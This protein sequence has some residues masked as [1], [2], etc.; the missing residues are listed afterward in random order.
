[1]S[2]ANQTFPVAGLFAAAKPM[3]TTGP[4]AAATAFAG[5]FAAA[6]PMTTTGPFSA[7]TAFDVQFAT[8]KPMT[9]T[10]PFVATTAFAG[11]FAATTAFAGPFAATKPMTTIGPFA[12]TK[13][14]TTIGP[15]AATKP[16]TTTG[17]FAINTK[18]MTTTGPFAATTPVKRKRQTVSNKNPENPEKPEKPH[19]KKSRK[20]KWQKGP[21]CTIMD[22]AIIKVRFLGKSITATSNKFCIPEKTLRRYVNAS[23]NP[24]SARGDF[25]FYHAVRDGEKVHSKNLRHKLEQLRGKLEHATSIPVL[26]SVENW[27][28]SK[29]FRELIQNLPPGDEY[30]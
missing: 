30:V 5:L 1:M 24:D 4:F 26:S 12:A 28:T 3:T 19:K 9:T 17:P 15:F 13:P 16:M 2:S 14:M 18:P 20:S 29:L 8:T 21:L 22:A 25:P 6:K 11:P 23:Q 7:A 10:G 27:R